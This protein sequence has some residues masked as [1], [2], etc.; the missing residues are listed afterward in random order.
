MLLFPTRD[1]TVWAFDEPAAAAAAAAAAFVVALHPLMMI[2]CSC[3]E[4]TWLH[5]TLVGEVT[6]RTKSDEFPFLSCC[7]CCCACH[8]SCCC[9]VRVVS[10]SSCRCRQRSTCVFGAEVSSYCEQ[11]SETYFDWYDLCQVSIFV[12]P[13]EVGTTLVILE[14]V[15]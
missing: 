12:Q 13:I 9:C 10:V 11:M 2:R 6:R 4:N 7:F 8:C 14:V 1:H 5:E 15:D 3:Y